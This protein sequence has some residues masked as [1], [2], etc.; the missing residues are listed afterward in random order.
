MWQEEVPGVLLVTPDTFF[1][2]ADESHPLVC[3]NGRDEYQ[4]ETS[5]LNITLVT[6]YHGTT[7]SKF[8]RY[9]ASRE[10]SSHLGSDSCM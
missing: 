6:I 10:I 2:D 4:F 3:Q 7:T 8:D 9:F 1:F 5:I